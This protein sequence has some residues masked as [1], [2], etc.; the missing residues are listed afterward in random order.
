MI[1]YLFIYS[2]NTYLRPVLCQTHKDE[3]H[4]VPP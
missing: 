1:K 2:K 4:T 3:A